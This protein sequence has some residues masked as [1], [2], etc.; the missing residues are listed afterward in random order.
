VGLPT[1]SHLNR[2]KVKGFSVS[3]I[4][5]LCRFFECGVGDLIVHIDTDTQ[6]GE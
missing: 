5:A 2:N 1:L 4:I 3:T 6:T